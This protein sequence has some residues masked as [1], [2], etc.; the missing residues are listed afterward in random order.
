MD[1]QMPVMNRLEAKMRIR[2]LSAEPAET[3]RSLPW[4]PAPCP[5]RGE[6]SSRRGWM[7]V[8]ASQWLWRICGGYRKMIRPGWVRRRIAGC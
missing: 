2:A 5:T 1:I 7:A 6:R 8:C 4:P 3:F